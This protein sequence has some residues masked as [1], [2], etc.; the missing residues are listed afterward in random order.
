MST[1]AAQPG[2]RTFVHRAERMVPREGVTLETEV[3]F[4]DGT[5]LR[6][7]LSDISSS[8][9]ACLVPDSETAAPASATRATRI[10]LSEGDQVRA[11]AA[12]A[13]TRSEPV[14]VASLNIGVTLVALAFDRPQA[15]LVESLLD[16]LAPTPY[17]TDSLPLFRGE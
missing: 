13:L 2:V 7:R 8:G 15:A 4:E 5:I 9:M 3:T 17:I 11:W 6:G 14:S 12:G 10:R 16:H 1:L